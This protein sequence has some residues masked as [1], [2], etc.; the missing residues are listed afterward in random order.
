MA[1][2]RYINIEIR[3]DNSYGFLGELDVDKKRKQYRIRFNNWVGTLDNPEAQV[4]LEKSKFWK[5]GV[6]QEIVPGDKIPKKPSKVSTSDAIN[7]ATGKG[8]KEDI[9]I[10]IKQ[11]NKLK[12]ENAELKAAALP[13]QDVKKVPKV[14]KKD[15]VKEDTEVNGEGVED[16]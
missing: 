9:T 4:A 12:R 7:T 3:G 15:V 13:Q 14:T 16:D 5:I 1:T 11:M 2:K 8:S 6:I 10:L